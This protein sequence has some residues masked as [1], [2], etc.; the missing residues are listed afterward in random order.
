MIYH[1]LR[2]HPPLPPETAPLSLSDY[3][4]SHL[5]TS[6]APETAAAFIDATTGR[7]I[8]FSQLVRFSETLAASLQRRLGLTRGDSALVISPNSLHV[9]VL[10][11][12]LFS[13]GV[14]V[15]PSNPASTE[16]EISRQI[17]LCKPVIAF[18]TSSTAHKVPSLKFS[19]V[20][21]DSPEFHSMMTV[22][23][24]NLRRVRVSQSDPAMILYSSGT[25]GRVKGVVLTHR[26]WISAVAGANVLRQER[27][28]PTVT[29]CT[30]P[31]F[32]VYGCGLCMRAVAL[33]QSVVAIE[34]LNVRSLMSAVQEFRVTH[35]AVA[36]PVIVMMANGGDL[37]D[38][39]DLRS[40]EAVLCGGAPVSTAVIE[41]FTKRF[42]NVQVTQAYGLTETTGGISRTV[43]LEESQRLGA[44]GRL[45]PYCQAKIVDP[46]TGIA[47][48]PLR[49][50]ELWVRGPSI[51]KGYVGNEE[52]TAE[53]LDS[54][55]WLRTG[56]ICHFDRDG[57]IYV[58]DRIKELIKYKGYQV[59]PAELEH[60]L[61]SHP[62]T[63]EAAVIPY[64]DAQAG[65]V[66]M[67]FVVKRPQSTI[68]E[69]EIMDFI[70]KQVAP[71]KKIR[72]VSFIN[73]IPKNAT[74]KVLRKDLIKLAS[75][76][77]GCSKL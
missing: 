26:N 1:S 27:A 7:S 24:G 18:A 13:L 74:G 57:F 70:A 51:M 62:D 29:M 32:H 8:S 22:E 15:S 71:Y 60:L 11:F 73:S 58:V 48:P 45:I 5:S 61:H 50:G 69:S 59:A 38:G 28:S 4:F 68:D 17:E 53:I 43:G 37:V 34:R 21:L 6:S 44:S 9:P 49:T 2:P 36:P 64:P 19:T 46:D 10:Y 76:R 39:C 47:L 66:P 54:E 14:I 16:S 30:V 67:A 40:L 75:S 31:Y 41:R 77:S 55:G 35:L 25:T 56:D 65:Q 12:A 20:V 23:T 3:V 63:V 33:G 42:P 52:A 72:R